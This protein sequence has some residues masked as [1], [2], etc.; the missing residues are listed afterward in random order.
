MCTAAEIPPPSTASANATLHA[1]A[2]GCATSARAASATDCRLIPR[3]LKL[4][5]PSRENKLNCLTETVSRSRWHLASAQYPSPSSR[6]C[7]AAAYRLT[8]NHSERTTM[9]SP[10][11]DSNCLAETIFR[12]AAQSAERLRRSRQLPGSLRPTPQVP[13]AAQKCACEIAPPS[14]TSRF[15][16]KL[17]I[18]SP[19]FAAR[20]A[21]APAVALECNRLNRLYPKRITTNRELD[22][23]RLTETTLVSRL[24]PSK[25]PSSEKHARRPTC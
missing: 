20:P 19:F 18:P 10:K 5:G 6:R 25:Q 23:N 3:D 14:A 16:R 15:S 22:L 7:R 17:D 12:L 2:A 1:P 8:I 11:L 21:M 13:Q 4:P 9:P 24:F